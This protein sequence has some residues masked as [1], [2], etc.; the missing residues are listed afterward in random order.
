MCV[1]C[2]YMLCLY[3]SVCVSVCVRKKKKKRETEPSERESDRG[4]QTDGREV[5]WRYRLCGG[6]NV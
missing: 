2:A 6:V 4:M 3:M 1:V 5:W